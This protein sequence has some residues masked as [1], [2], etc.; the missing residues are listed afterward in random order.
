MGSATRARS[1]SAADEGGA[2]ARES[3]SGVVVGDEDRPYAMVD[4][5][6][7]RALRAAELGDLG[8][9]EHRNQQYGQ[10]QQRNLG[11]VGVS[12]I[13]RRTPAG[14]ATASL[15]PTQSR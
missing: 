1:S 14:T 12:V 11:H 8:K 6:E 13:A 2:V 3:E 15:A 9:H 5:V 10:C 7:P 4:N